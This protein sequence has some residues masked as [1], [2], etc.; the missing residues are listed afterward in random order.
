MRI[1]ASLNHLTKIPALVVL[2]RQA[3]DLVIAE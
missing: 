1:L 3:R 2:M